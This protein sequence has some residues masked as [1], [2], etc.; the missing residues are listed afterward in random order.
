[1]KKKNRI[2]YS[3]DTDDIQIVAESELNRTL[4][5]DELKL[6]EEKLGD[7][8]DWYEAIAMAIGELVSKQD[9]NDEDS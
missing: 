2:V 5:E 6:V 8:F 9:E 1:M 7:Y 4:S 3:L